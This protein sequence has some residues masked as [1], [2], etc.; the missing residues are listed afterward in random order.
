MSIAGM[1]CTPGVHPTM[2]AWIYL[3]AKSSTARPLKAAGGWRHLIFRVQTAHS[4]DFV[5]FIP[6]V[7]TL[8]PKEPSQYYKAL[9]EETSVLEHCNQVSKGCI[10]LLEKKKK[11]FYGMSLA[12]KSNSDETLIRILSF[13]SFS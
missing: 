13:C 9:T 6:Q 1:C 7:L 10:A 5:R 2:R 4:L 12:P 3:P 11:L 8:P